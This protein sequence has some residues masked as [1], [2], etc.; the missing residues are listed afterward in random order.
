MT[1]FGRR[2]YENGSAG[3]DHG[4]GFA[5]LAMGAKV[6][7]GTVHGDWPGLDENALP[8]VGPAGLAVRIDYRS[9]L[10]EVLSRAIGN[11]RTAEVF[12]AFTPQRVGLV[13]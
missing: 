9:V 8:Y 12:P 1:E 4:R 3:T 10:A 13:A 7:G 2:L 11:T 6:N 5:M